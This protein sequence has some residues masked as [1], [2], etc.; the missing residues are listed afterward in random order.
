MENPEEMFYLRLPFSD[1]FISIK[2]EFQR[3]K[4][5]QFRKQTFECFRGGKYSEEE[6]EF[7]K[8]K[9]GELIEMQG[10]LSTSLKR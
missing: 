2:E 3:Q 7:F 8:K 9:K 6:I 5:E 4:N 1:L 10:F